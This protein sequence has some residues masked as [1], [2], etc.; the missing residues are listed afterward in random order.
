MLRWL[1]PC[2]TACHRTTRATLYAHSLS[3]CTDGRCARFYGSRHQRKQLTHDHFTA[4][5][6]EYIGLASRQSAWRPGSAGVPAAGGERK[7]T[8]GSATRIQVMPPLRSVVTTVW[9]REC[10][11][12]SIAQLRFAGSCAIQGARVAISSWLGRSEFARQRSLRYAGFAPL[13]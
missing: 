13:T 5:R 4:E 10:C 7:H 11:P 12:L 2:A 1:K 9:S 6:Y 8:N 3:S